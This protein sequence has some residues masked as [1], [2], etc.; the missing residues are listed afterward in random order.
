MWS[1]LTGPKKAKCDV[2]NWRNTNSET[3]THPGGH[4]GTQ[5][6]VSF[7]VHKKKMDLIGELK[8]DQEENVSDSPKSV[9]TKRCRTFWKTWVL[10]QSLKLTQHSTIRASQ[11]HS[12][13]VEMRLLCCSRTWTTCR[14]LMLSTK[15]SWRRTPIRRFR[16]SRTT[17]RGLV[18]V[19]TWIRKETVPLKNNKFCKQ[20]H[21]RILPQ[22]FKRTF[23][24]S[25]WHQVWSD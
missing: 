7:K 11:Q 16:C 19:L 5:R 1:K 6:N 24:C 25:Y 13:T 17:I 4:R 21:G 22:W 23:N 8:G 12:N 3:T 10:F 9:L 15:K 20:K 2:A 14:K 18:K